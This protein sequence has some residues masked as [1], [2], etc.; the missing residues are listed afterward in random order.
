[1]KADEINFVQV[2][3]NGGR[4]ALCACPGLERPL[5]AELA[6]L[7]D[8][9]ARGLVTL[10]EDHEFELLGVR[11]LPGQVESL[12]MRWWH[13]PIRDRGTPDERFERRWQ[14]SG[15]ELRSLLREG[16]SIALHCHGGL[17]RTGTIAARLLVEMGS[18]PGV[19]IARVRRARKGTIE[20]REQEAFVHGCRALPP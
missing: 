12:G 15:G 14:Q 4:I 1:M 11:S 10:I 17:G 19:A 9:G 16:T 5:A 2:S 13:F 3:D 18:E 7:L 20:T 8:W 6:R